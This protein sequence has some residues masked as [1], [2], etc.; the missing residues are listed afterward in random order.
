MDFFSLCAIKT[1]IGIFFFDSRS[2]NRKWNIF[3]GP[4]NPYAKNDTYQNAPP[5]VRTY[6]GVGY[7]E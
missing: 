7:S 3:L 6:P 5:E 2:G 4:T 1:T